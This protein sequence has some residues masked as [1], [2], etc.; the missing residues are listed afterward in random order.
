MYGL[1]QMNIAAITTTEAPDDRPASFASLP[2][3]TVV[4]AKHALVTI[5][6]ATISMPTSS[7]T[8]AV[9]QAESGVTPRK[10]SR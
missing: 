7:V 9:T 4:A 10:T 1:A 8:P 3:S 5:F 6:T 2:E